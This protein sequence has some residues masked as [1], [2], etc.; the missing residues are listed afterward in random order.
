MKL[1]LLKHIH[2][3]ISTL[4]VIP[5][6]L[7]YGSRPDLLFDVK[8]N[9]TD[10]GNIFRAIMGLYLSFALLWVLGIF[11]TEYWKT[12]TIS[13]ICFMLGLAF[14]RIINIALKGLPSKIF[15]IG[16]VGELILG[17]YSIYILNKSYKVL[18]TPAN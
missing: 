17:F 4:I 8:I 18:K 5:I 2:L 6:G 11:K 7:I 12:A 1:K 14:G 3:I 9:S 10:E 15:V 13:N 16:T